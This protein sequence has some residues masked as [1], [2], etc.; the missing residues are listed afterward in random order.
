MFQMSQG[1]KQRKKRF[2]IHQSMPAFPVMQCFPNR[3]SRTPD[4][5]WEEAYTCTGW[6]SSQRTLRNGMKTINKYLRNYV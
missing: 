3:S 5:T 1:E 2:V 4:E 6:G